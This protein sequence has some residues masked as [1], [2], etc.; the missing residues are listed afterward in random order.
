MTTTEYKVYQVSVERFL[1]TNCVKPGCYS[2]VTPEE[3]TRNEFS[4][5]PC[6]C[7]NRRLGG[8]RERYH[9]GSEAGLL[10]AEICDDCV[11]YLTYGQ[12]DDMTM[13]DMVE[14]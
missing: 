9:F 7:C 3:P 13:M 2:N 14:A 10:A 11:Y 8:A 4:W 1:N 12:L 6:E 5:C